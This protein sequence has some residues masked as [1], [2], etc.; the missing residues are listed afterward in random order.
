MFRRQF[1]HHEIFEIQVSKDTQMDSGRPQYYFLCYVFKA[2]GVHEK[3][4]NLW[5]I[6]NDSLIVI[7]TDAADQEHY[8]LYF[9][10]NLQ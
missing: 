5:E 9:I 1:L 6:S 7:M 10:E 8:E 2:D 3:I 4:E